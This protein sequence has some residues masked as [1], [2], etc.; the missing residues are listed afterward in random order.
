VDGNSEKLIRVLFDIALPQQLGW[1]NEALRRVGQPAI[2][3]AFSAFLQ[4]RPPLFLS[5]ERA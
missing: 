5:A 4:R 1:E 3:E 2:K